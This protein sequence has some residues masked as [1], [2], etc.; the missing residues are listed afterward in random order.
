MTHSLTLGSLLLTDSLPDTTHDFKFDVLADGVGFGVAAGVKEVVTSLLSDGDLIRTTRYG[1]REVSFVV[2]I[3]GP[4]LGSLAH[5]EAALR[6]EIGRGNTLTWQ[7][8]D[9]FALP[10]VFEVVA[11]EMAQKFDDLDELNKR[12][13]YTLTL[14]CSPFA[15]SL[16]PVD[17]PALVSGAA[18]LF[19]IDDASSASAWS[20]ADDGY[21]PPSVSASGG[22]VAVVGTAMTLLVGLN[23]PTSFA[24]TRYL[25]VEVAT[26]GLPMSL[27]VGLTEIAPSIVRTLSSGHSLYVYDMVDHPSVTAF[28]FSVYSPT[29][30]TKSLTFFD[31]SRS[32]AMPQVTPR[33]ITRV[34]AG[35]GTERTP[36]SIKV[37]SPTSAALGHTIVHT[38]PETGTGYSPPLRRWR[39]DGNSPVTTEAARFSGAYEATEPDAFVAQV[40]NSA[41]PAG[42]YLLVARLYSTAAGTF[43][44]SWAAS[45]IVNSVPQDQQIGDES[46]T[47]PA[48][49][50]HTFPLAVLSLPTVRSLGPVTQ[51]SIQTPTGD[52]V[53]TQLDEAW[54]FLMGE[55]CGLTIV[56][57]PTEN[58]WLDSP[59]ITSGVPRVWIGDIDDRSDARH[60]AAGLQAFGSH[61]IS[62][63]G[64]ALF[65]AAEVDNPAA[66]AQFYPRWHSNA[67][68]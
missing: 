46:V 63:G 7:P 36:G 9:D 55:D 30:N 48:A 17:V 52:A 6:R 40:P 54:L 59:D 31:V 10:T 68:E 64:T 13:K 43:T 26:N 5:G 50:W 62:P 45:T 57:N 38:C 34:I 47:F 32:A 39:F 41:L 28:S 21:G 3:T 60:P 11:S 27:R 37:S 56:Q 61:I 15:R 33:Q 42:D 18:T 67:A 12:R 4:D 58:L 22:A 49:G 2:E 24:S 51:I 20:A 23:V 35:R 44:V 8:P 65:T 66:S 25:L 14:T 1:N 19:T 16:N 29:A 53:T